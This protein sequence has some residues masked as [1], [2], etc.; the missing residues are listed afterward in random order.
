VASRTDPDVP[1]RV[2]L[3][4]SHRHGLRWVR[5][6]LRWAVRPQHRLDQCAAD[7]T[8]YRECRRYGS[9]TAARPSDPNC[10]LAQASSQILGS[11]RV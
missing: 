9:R 11:L 2:G 6:E 1:C 5:L 4:R 7:R 3:Y 10:F 8:V